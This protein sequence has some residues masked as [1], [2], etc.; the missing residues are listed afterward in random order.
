M[1]KIIATTF[2]TDVRM[3]VC[4]TSHH[5]A[6]QPSNIPKKKRT[7]DRHN[8]ATA[9]RTITEITKK[10]RGLLSI[11][12]SF[13][14]VLSKK[15]ADRLSGHKENIEKQSFYGWILNITSA[16]IRLNGGCVHE[17]VS[18]EYQGRRRRNGGGRGM[19]MRNSFEVD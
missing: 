6:S 7:H 10:S 2:S 9:K 4:T 1:I 14:F 16:V 12:H 3:Y 13:Q 19:K 5:T 18:E 11:Q 15:L 8:T 17:S